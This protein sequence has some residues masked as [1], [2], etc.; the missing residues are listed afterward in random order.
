LAGSLKNIWEVCEFEDDIKYGR[1]EPARFTVE[2]WQVIDGSADKIY[3]VPHFS[4]P[5]TFMT[6]NVKYLLMK[7]LRRL[8]GCEGQPIFV[9]DTREKPKI[10]LSYLRGIDKNIYLN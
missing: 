6:E 1:L 3:T 2:L 4:L 9:L 5:H 7:A 8:S 10:F